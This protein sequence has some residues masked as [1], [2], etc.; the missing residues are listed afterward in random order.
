[1]RKS[2]EDE[3]RVSLGLGK[4][5]KEDALID[6]FLCFLQARMVWRS[7]GVE[8]IK[9]EGLGPEGLEI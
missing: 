5:E 1:M 3:R 8:P 9:G 6:L 7:G 4:R 2:G